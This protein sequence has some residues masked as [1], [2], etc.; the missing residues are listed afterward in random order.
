MGF[1]WIGELIIRTEHHMV[2]NQGGGRVQDY[3]NKSSLRRQGGTWPLGHRTLTAGPCC[4]WIYKTIATKYSCYMKPGVSPGLT[5][6]C[7]PIGRES[8]NLIEDVTVVGLSFVSDANSTVFNL[9]GSV[10]EGK[11]RGF[12]IF[13]KLLNAEDLSIHIDNPNGS[14]FPI[15]KYRDARARCHLMLE[16]KQ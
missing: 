13:Q 3:D 12:I 14:F 11:G 4:L 16:L 1:L 2:K 10:G 5:N 8:R 7:K 9:T 6:A 15:S